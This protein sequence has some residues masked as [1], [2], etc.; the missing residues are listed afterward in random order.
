MK[1]KQ[2]H[3]GQVTVNIGKADPTL[4]FY[5]QSVSVKVAKRGDL[6]TLFP[7]Y[8]EKAS[9]FLLKRIKFIR[10]ASVADPDTHYFALGSGSAFLNCDL[11]I[12]KKA[13]IILYEKS[14]DSLKSESAFVLRLL[15]IFSEE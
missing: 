1:D 9:L 10:R 5:L 14:F 13:E 11:T 3:R 6:S 7:I 12:S 8:W 2:V 4:V 15:R